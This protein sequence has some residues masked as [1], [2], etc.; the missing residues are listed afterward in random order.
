MRME[1]I[2]SYGQKSKMDTG[3][4][5]WYY[6]TPEKCNFAEKMANSNFPLKIYNFSRSRM[7]KRI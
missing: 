4:E 7:K 6:K 5:N 1:K 3:T 2:A